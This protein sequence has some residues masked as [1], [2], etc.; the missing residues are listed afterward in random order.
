MGTTLY[1]I[2]TASYAPTA[3]LVF[4][5]IFHLLTFLSL[6]VLAFKDPGILPKILSSFESPNLTQIPIDNRYITCEA[7]DFEKIFILTTKTHLLKFK[8]CTICF[9]YQPPR[10]SHCYRC[11]VCVERFDHHCPWIGTCV[12]KR[13]YRWFFTFLVTLSL[14]ILFIWIQNFIVV[15]KKDEITV[16][17][18]VIN[19]ILSIYVS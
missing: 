13:N 19:I 12:G 6:I 9:I 17:A 3:L 16:G 1:Y 2:F 10:T 7:T 14:L 15:T 18:F 4:V 11:N 8:F 5:I